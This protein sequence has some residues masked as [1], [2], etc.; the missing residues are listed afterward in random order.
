MSLHP[1][2]EHFEK[3][4]DDDEGEDEDY[5][6]EV[7]HVEDKA[8]ISVAKYGHWFEIDYYCELHVY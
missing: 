6:P 7:D 5:V 1:K 4:E 3:D 2:L 8:E